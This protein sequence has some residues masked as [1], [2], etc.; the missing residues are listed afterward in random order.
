MCRVATGD[1]PLHG[2]L[3]LLEGAGHVKWSGLDWE[4][5]I[6]GLVW[7]LVS[8]LEGVGGLPLILLVAHHRRDL[9]VLCNNKPLSCKQTA[10]TALADIQQR[11]SLL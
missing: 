11:I 8:H 6:L 9:M 10:P 5:A 3:S 1:T 7:E 2:G 4:A